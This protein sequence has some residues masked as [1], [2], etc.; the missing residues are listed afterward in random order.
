MSSLRSNNVCTFGYTHI[1]MACG[2]KNKRRSRGKK[3]LS[4]RFMISFIYFFPPFMFISLWEW[5]WKSTSWQCTFCIFDDALKLSVV[6][7]NSKWKHSGITIYYIVI[8]FMW[9]N[10][11]RD[12]SLLS[13]CEYN[14]N[15]TIL[16]YYIAVCDFSNTKKKKQ[17]CASERTAHF[18]LNINTIFPQYNIALHFV[19]CHM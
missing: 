14:S 9:H 4:K 1:D 19:Q 5:E 6:I 10:P 2:N 7:E 15:N 17:R 11:L 13:F 12:I 18:T 8:V 3:L 16:S